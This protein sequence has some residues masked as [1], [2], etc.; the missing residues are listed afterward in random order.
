[1]WPVTKLNSAHFLRDR[2]PRRSQIWVSC[3]R[4]S[5]RIGGT[6]AAKSTRG[7]RIRGKP[8][9]GEPLKASRHVAQIQLRS[10]VVP[11]FHLVEPDVGGAQ[12]LFDGCPVFRVD[13]PT[14]A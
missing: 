13:G 2:A 8:T 12:K 6:R 9:I 11:A 1:M 14:N 10:F 3:S 4:A 7:K 5:L